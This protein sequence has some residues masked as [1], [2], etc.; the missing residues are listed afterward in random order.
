MFILQRGGTNVSWDEV[1]LFGKVFLIM[2]VG[3]LILN[4]L[5]KMYLLATSAPD[6]KAQKFGTP[7]KFIGDDFI[8]E[9]NKN[10]SARESQDK[11]RN[12]DS[13]T[14]FSFT[15][16]YGSD[17][18]HPT[19]DVSIDYRDSDIKIEVVLKAGK[20]SETKT[21]SCPYNKSEAQRI[22][23]KAMDSLLTSHREYEKLYGKS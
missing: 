6:R 10:Y 2:I 20:T 16:S 15:V 9:A 3:G 11:N 7:Y 18:K 8:Y 17:K 19:F 5:Y 4:F 13:Q 1:F 12:S 22:I 23:L 21:Y 14:C